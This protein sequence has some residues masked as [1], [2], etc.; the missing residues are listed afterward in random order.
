MYCSSILDKYFPAKLFISMS[1]LR[2]IYLETFL[3][4][5]FFCVEMY[6]FGEEKII[7]YLVVQ[8]IVW[9]RFCFVLFFL[10]YENVLL[11][12]LNAHEI[13]IM[14]PFVCVF[15]NAVFISCMYRHFFL[16][17]LWFRSFSATKCIRPFWW[18]PHT[19]VYLNDGIKVLMKIE[20]NH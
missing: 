19:Y 7:K 13:G 5:F 20:G 9:V 14:S 18:Y 12:M 11:R 1:N 6:H 10:I 8:T 4:L 2:H 3:F 15:R 16:V 17:L